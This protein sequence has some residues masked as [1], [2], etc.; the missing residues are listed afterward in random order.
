MICLEKCA[1]RL[2]SLNSQ[3]LLNV[4]REGMGGVGVAGRGRAGGGWASR[5]D[6][7]MLMQR[8]DM[9]EFE[10]DFRDDA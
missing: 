8:Y 9:A 7:R 10:P 2:V 3:M 5:D 6:A 1:C 4:F